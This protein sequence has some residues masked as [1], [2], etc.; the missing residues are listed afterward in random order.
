MKK[1]PIILSFLIAVIIVALVAFNIF[2]L[3]S[4]KKQKTQVVAK[5]SNGLTPAQIAANAK[6]APTSIPTPVPSPRPLTFA[7]LNSMYGPC[8]NLPVLFYH[9]IQNMDV[10]KAAGQQNL[11]VATDIFISQMHYLKDHGYITLA[12]N[13]LTDFFDKGVPVPQTGVILT[14]DDGYTDFYVNVVPILRELGFKAVLALPTGLVG[15]PGY[16]TWDEISQAASSGVEV[17]NHTW[18]HANL[19]T[20]NKDLVQR[21]VVTAE[22][23][24][25][26][27][28]YNANKA[29]V[30][31]YGGY[32]DYAVSFLQSKGYTLAFTTVLGST[33]CK[34]HRLTLPRIRIGNANLS[35]YG[36]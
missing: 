34:Q 14:F 1:L 32:N 13:S 10:A 33:L 23:Q 30:Y 4:L 20:N 18:S 25:M 11:T 9:H 24:L 12:T 2:L 7:D 35:A 31:P 17:I 21:E 28:G 19:A 36:F 29:L 5:I 16:L 22:E 26:Q 3:A 8:T 15:N 6:P 27:R